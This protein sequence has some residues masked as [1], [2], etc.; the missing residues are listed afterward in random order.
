[1]NISSGAGLRSKILDQEGRK[2]GVR[3][4]ILLH[5]MVT[6]HAEQDETSRLQNY[7][8]LRNLEVIQNEIEFECV[9]NVVVIT[10]IKN[11]KPNVEKR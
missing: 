6:R 3:K 2:N 5:F 7:V 11:N 4:D 8:K 10:A 9:I 1:M